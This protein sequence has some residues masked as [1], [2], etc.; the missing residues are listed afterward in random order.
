MFC[1]AGQFPIPRRTT[2]SFLLKSWLNVYLQFVILELGSVESVDMLFSTSFSL[3]LSMLAS[4]LEKST[5]KPLL[6]NHGRE[7]GRNQDCVTL[8][9]VLD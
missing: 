4:K 6:N 3:S 9:G 8:A 7:I 5:E 1:Q 2:L